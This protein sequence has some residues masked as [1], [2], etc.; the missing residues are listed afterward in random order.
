MSGG[1]TGR[2]PPE[3]RQGP[4]AG[5][6]CYRHTDRETYISC[7]RC[8]RP[9][10]PECMRQA[11]V[12]FQCPECVAQGRASAP[13]TRTAYG[14]IVR[15]GENVV[16]LTLI[17]LN[18]V[19]FLLIH[20]TG[21]GTSPLLL[22]SALTSGAFPFEGPLGEGVSDGQL[23]RLVTSMFVHVDPLHLLFNMFALWIF[24]PGLERL[25][26]R[27]RFLALYM[28][29]GLAGSVAV[30]WLA[31]PTTL[32]YGASGAVFGLLGAALV[33]SVRRGYDVGWLLGLLA[34]NLVFSF[35]AQ[36]ISWQGHLGGLVG[37][38][39]MG[40]ALAWAPR[41]MRTLVQAAAF[42]GVFVLCVLLIAVRSSQLA[43]LA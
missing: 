39:A 31:G 20:A 13:R 18:V 7:Q 25:L 17:A 23:W 6:R 27:W 3:P 34:I 4:Q 42:V 9:I 22:N 10:C 16:T 40:A 43:A 1:V 21:G 8:S 19:M 36:G 28:L 15:G 2:Q 37:G 26:G 11:S 33:V 5:P 24:G 41:R 12:G 35:M 30:Y 38:L 14:G 32:T 29:S